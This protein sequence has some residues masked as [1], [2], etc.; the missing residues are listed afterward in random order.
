MTLWTIAFDA[1]ISVSVEAD[2]EGEAIGMAEEIVGSITE[3]DLR[4]GDGVDCS[5]S[6]IF[7]IRNQS[8]GE[9]IL[10]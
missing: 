9:E 1:T 5:I 8:T 4:L 2:A 3:E 6:K 7:L 10:K